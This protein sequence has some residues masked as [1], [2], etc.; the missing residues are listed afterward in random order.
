MSWHCFVLAA[1]PGER[2]IISLPTIWVK[3]GINGMPF[4][5]SCDAGVEVLVP[6]TN[7]FLGFGLKYVHHCRSVMETDRTSRIPPIKSH[8]HS[9]H[10]CSHHILQN[11]TN[12]ICQYTVICISSY[13]S[14]STPHAHHFNSY[15]QDK[16]GL[17]LESLSSHPYPEHLHGNN[18]NSSYPLGCT[19]KPT[20]MAISQGVLKQKF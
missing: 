13:K 16:P 3:F 8:T 7:I 9:K 6:L 1:A 18:Q 15:F 19:Q 12:V 14:T 20:T 5:M 2:F 11:P 10:N 17:P 4:C